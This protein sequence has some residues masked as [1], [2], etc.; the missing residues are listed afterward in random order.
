VNRYFSTSDLTISFYI[1]PTGTTPFKY[2]LLTKRDS[3]N[4]GP[5]LDFQLNGSFGRVDIE[6]RENEYNYFSGL[7]AELDAQQWQHIVLVRKGIYAYTFING[8]L[9]QKSR[10]CR[11]VDISNTTNLRFSDSPCMG[12]GLRRFKGV[13]DELKIFNRAFSEEEVLQLFHSVPL[14]DVNQDCFS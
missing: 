4:L 14:E 12:P 7:S 8:T 10:K 13:L 1:K 5:Q 2:Q 6:C 3:C 9:R 11:G